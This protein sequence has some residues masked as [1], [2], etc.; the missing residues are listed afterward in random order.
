LPYEK[1]TTAGKF[2]KVERIEDFLSDGERTSS[3][4]LL[5]LAFRLLESG[6]ESG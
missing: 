2:R 3:A 5:K 6:D 4:V 1:S